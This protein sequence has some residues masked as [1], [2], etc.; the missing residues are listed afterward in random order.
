MNI[1]PHTALASSG[2]AAH[3]LVLPRIIPTSDYNFLFIRGND[4]MVVRCHADMV[5]EAC[6]RKIVTHSYHA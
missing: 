1:N 4:G 5:C 3:T 2:C 6:V